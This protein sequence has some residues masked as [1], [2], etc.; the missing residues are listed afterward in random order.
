VILYWRFGTTCGFHLQGSRRLLGL[1]TLEDGTDTFPQTSVK[2]YHSTLYNIP[3][4]GRS[5]QNRGGSLK[6]RTI[7]LKI[8]D[9]LGLFYAW[10]VLSVL[11]KARVCVCVSVGN[12]H[13]LANEEARIGASQLGRCSWQ[14]SQG[15]I[16]SRLSERCR[17]QRY[18]TLAGY[19]LL[20]LCVGTLVG[21]SFPRFPK[22]PAAV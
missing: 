8:L 6:S 9:S 19:H 11:M 16:P 17:R 4:E 3:D 7:F 5:H 18:S 21:G 14:P 10:S 1:L 2:D 22:T 20:L 13:R 15:C 12:K